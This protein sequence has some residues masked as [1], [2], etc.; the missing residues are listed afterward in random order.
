MGAAPSNAASIMTEGINS[1]E[2][3]LQ[4]GS[5][6]SVQEEIG[7]EYN[8][9]WYFVDVYGEKVGPNLA[10][11]ILGDLF[12][13]KVVT[14]K[15]LV[16][17]AKIMKEWKP[18]REVCNQFSHPA[19]SKSKTSVSKVKKDADMKPYQLSI[20]TMLGD[21]NCKQAKALLINAGIK[22]TE[23]NVDEMPDTF[24]DMVR[25]TRERSTPQIVVNGTHIG[26]YEYLKEM[27]QND[28]LMKV[29][30]ET[31][32]NKHTMKGGV[33]S[34][35]TTDSRSLTT[36]VV[37]DISISLA[38]TNKLEADGATIHRSSSISSDLK[39]SSKP[40]EVVAGSESEIM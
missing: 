38:I 36:A 12:R 27:V 32:S 10:S 16:W 30:S 14:P 1:E 5:L 13:D 3:Y 19:R 23:I 9:N 22:F 25:I 28:T 26:N 29:I 34:N 7:V 6:L 21:Y 39:S 8:K 4:L 35:R 40:K 20:Y 31:A 37:V 33:I 15:T 17:R 11:Y 2:D 24:E 18:L